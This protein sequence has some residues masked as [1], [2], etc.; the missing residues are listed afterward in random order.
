MHCC[1][2]P[3]THTS[4]LLPTPVNEVEP[5]NAIQCEWKKRCVWSFCTF[6]DQFKL[7][8][9]IQV[10]KRGHRAVK[11][12]IQATKGGWLATI[13]CMTGI[14]CD[15]APHPHHQCSRH[16]L[17]LSAILLSS[18]FLFV[19][20]IISLRKFSTAMLNNF[21]LETTAVDNTKRWPQPCRQ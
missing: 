19:S 14:P 13:T 6:I 4:S 7:H 1:N 12:V 2:V 9:S 5:R 3:T 21:P 20:F 11:A 8:L 10:L 18:L 16:R 15:K 17:Q